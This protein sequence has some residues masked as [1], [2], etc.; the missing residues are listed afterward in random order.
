[1]HGLLHR[2]AAMALMSLAFA[3]DELREQGWSYV[4][5]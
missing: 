5:P 4:R 2:R 3:D 1:M